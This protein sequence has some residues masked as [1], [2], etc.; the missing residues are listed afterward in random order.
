MKT[1]LSPPKMNWLKVCPKCG[2]SDLLQV[3]ITAGVASYDAAIECL[4][5]HV[6][7]DPV[8]VSGEYT[9]SNEASVKAALAAECEAGKLWNQLKA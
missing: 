2:H 7:G 6:A 9:E 3:R 8:T 5:C 1:I 4:R